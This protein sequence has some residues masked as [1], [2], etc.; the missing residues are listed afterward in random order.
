MRFICSPLFAPYLVSPLL[1]WLPQATV[2]RP[3]I[4]PVPLAHRPTAS[5]PMGKSS[6]CFLPAVC[7][8]LMAVDIHSHSAEACTRLS[9]RPQGPCRGRLP[10]MALIKEVKSWGGTLTLAFARHTDSC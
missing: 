10:R 9:P 4:S 5:M 7:Q 1:L 8:I 2:L 6:V 3:L